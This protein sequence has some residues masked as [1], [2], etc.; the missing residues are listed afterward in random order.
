MKVVDK[1]TMQALDRHMIDNMNIPSLQL[2]E[3]AALGMTSLI[4]DKF[5]TSTNITVV[6]GAGNNGGDGFA[7]ARQLKEKGY[8]VKAYLIGKINDLKADAKTNA[9]LFDGNTIETEDISVMDIDSCG[10]IIDALFGIGL[11]RIITGLNAEVIKKINSSRAYKI[12]CDI[13]SGIDADTGNILGVAVKAD[14]T[15]TFECAK[16]GHL[17]FPGRYYTGI[18]TVHEIGDAGDLDTGQTEAIYED[19]FLPGREADSHK[20]CFGKLACIVGSRGMS[21]AGM[22]CAR[23]ALK[24][25]A[26]LTTVGIPY[27]LQDI[28]SISVPECLTYALD[29]DQGA[30]S[31]KCVPGIEELMKNKTALAAGCGLS[32]CSGTKKAIEHLIKNYDIKKVFDADALNIISQDISLLKDKAGEIVLTPHKGEFARLIGEEVSEPLRQVKEF[33]AKYSVTMLLKG[34]T[35]IVSDGEKTALIMAGTPGMAKGGSGDVLTGVI[36]GLLAGGMNCFDAAVYGA[37]I[38]GKAGERAAEIHGEYSMTASD[39]LAQI[40]ATMK[41]MII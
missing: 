25:G 5:D 24:G 22:L 35:T 14:E 40:G 37:Y 16:P 9:E 7:A 17:L 32:V 33:A 41:R 36:G 2:M 20:G 28:Y 26:G 21:G 23:G 18:L 10:V 38:C 1:K 8:S 3:N 39:T 12:A 11:S 4:A 30:L 31:Y 19:I 6:C 27:S 29:E 34:A 13:P 15:V